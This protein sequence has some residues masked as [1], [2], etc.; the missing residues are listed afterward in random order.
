MKEY[1]IFIFLSRMDPIVDANYKGLRVLYHDKNNIE[2]S[3]LFENFTSQ[4][5]FSLLRC[6]ACSYFVPESFSSEY[7]GLV[8]LFPPEKGIPYFH[9]WRECTKTF[10]ND[11]L[12]FYKIRSP[13]V[14]YVGTDWYIPRH[15]IGG[16]PTFAYSKHFNTSIIAMPW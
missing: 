8:I 4:T 16:L 10:I 13:F 6:H 12:L 15:K 7:S 11:S 2:E 9:D 1:F 3:K 14:A 5:Y